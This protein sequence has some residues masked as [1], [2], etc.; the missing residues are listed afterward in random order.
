VTMAS[1]R[2]LIDRLG[3]VSDSSLER[4]RAAPGDGISGGASVALRFKAGDR[5]VDLATGSRAVV[6]AAE[7]R[8]GKSES[9]YTLELADKRVVLRGDGE[10][11]A[12]E[13][14]AVK[15]AAL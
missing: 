9:L 15:P 1:N 6:R 14:I 4:L 8:A 10:I 13:A 3:R 5:V 2:T 7:P 12:D 11:A